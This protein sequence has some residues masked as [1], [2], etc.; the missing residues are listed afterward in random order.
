M[1]VKRTKEGAEVK[2]IYSTVSIAAVKPNRTCT[3]GKQAARQ[4][5]H[6]IQVD[7]CVQSHSSSEISEKDTNI[8]DNQLL[9]I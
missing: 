6:F 3:E 1:L 4:Q 5:R 8:G 2:L 7:A 9:K